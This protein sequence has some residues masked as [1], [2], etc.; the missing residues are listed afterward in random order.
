M[1]VGFSAA[2]TPA[3]WCHA[4]CAEYAV[5]IF[6]GPACSVLPSWAGARGISNT[7][8]ICGGYVDCAE[9]G[10][11]VIWTADGRIIELPPSADGGIPGSPFKINSAGQ[12]VGRMNV[13]G[14]S[15][16]DRAF[17]YAD[18]VTQ[19]LGTLLGGNYSEAAAINA[20]GTVCGYSTGVGQPLTAF[21]W[22]D[23]TMSAL[24]LP[25]GTD[26]VANDISDTGEVCGWMGDLPWLA[27][28]YIWSASRVIDL[29]AVLPGANGASATGLNNSGNV[30]GYSLYGDPSEPIM[31]RGF[32]WT[33][34]TVLDLGIL[35]GFTTATPTR[36]NDFN[37]IVGSCNS[38]PISGL[39]SAFVWQNGIMQDLND[40][41]PPEL[42]LNIDSAYD[43]NNAGQIVAQALRRGPKGT[44][45]VAVRL[46]PIPKLLGDFNCD[47]IINVDDLIGVISHWNFTTPNL[48]FD[49][50][51][52]V[53]VGD[54]L[55]VL[56][57]WTL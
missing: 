20:S 43:I 26:S 19:N 11:H 28:G 22:Q 47:R 57:N 31:R 39:T 41:V 12:V 2:V 51:G 48:D 5:E 21:V 50:S 14:L 15:P 9:V 1:L 36:L 44:D 6:A 18:G 13:P 53:G 10:H 42:N 4:Q 54:L 16:P 32:F 34:G 30:C 3:L 37:V 7:G 24:N 8:S 38:F 35:P 40:L 25:F 55:I 27:H 56:D 45:T 17:L 52:T 33:N 49:G 46:T 23:G 29:G